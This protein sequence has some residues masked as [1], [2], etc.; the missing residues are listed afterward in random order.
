VGAVKVNNEKLWEMAKVD[1]TIRGFS[2]EG[3]FAERAT[4]RPKEQIA[5]ELKAARKLLEIKKAIIENE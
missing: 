2:I 1:G 5:E 4:Q 3:F